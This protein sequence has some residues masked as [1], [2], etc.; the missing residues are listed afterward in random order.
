LVVAIDD[1]SGWRVIGADLPTFGKG[2]WYGPSPRF[3]LVIGSDARPGEDP[4]A[5]RADSL[6]ILTAVPE[7]RAGAIVGIPRDSW[8]ASPSG[9]R[10]KITN[11]LASHGPGG[12]LATVQSLSGL[13][14]EGY[15]ITGFGGF[16]DLVNAFG[17]VRVEVPFGMSDRAS[18]AFFEA[19]EQ[20][21]HGW[22]A[23]AFSRNRHI[24]GG[25][26]TRSLHQGVV[27]KAALGQIQQAGIENLPRNLAILTQFVFTDFSLEHL[28][29]L[30]ATSYL[31][32]PAQV[33]NVVVPGSVGSVGAASVVFLGD[34]AQTVFADLADG[35]LTPPQ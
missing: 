18:G 8:L 35:T 9:G 29:S 4:L 34:G 10:T 6:H 28:T 33:P 19:G 14:L 20:D 11:I 25:D 12:I 30:A 22:D 16:V 21:M 27:I 15:L 1:G 2:P 5:Q 31:L 26:F 32:D 17:S 23:L 13:P 3:V 24:G 7:Q